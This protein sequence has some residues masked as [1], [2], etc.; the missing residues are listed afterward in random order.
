MGFSCCIFLVL[1]IIEFISS[2]SLVLYSISITLIGEERA[3]V[4]V[5]VYQL[6]CTLMLPLF[7][8]PIWFYAKGYMWFMMFTLHHHHCC[9][10]T[11]KDLTNIWCTNLIKYKNKVPKF[12]VWICP[13]NMQSNKQHLFACN[14][15]TC[16]TLARTATVKANWQSH[17]SHPKLWRNSNTSFQSNDIKIY[18]TLKEANSNDVIILKQNSTNKIAITEEEWT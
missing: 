13:W 6:A 15:N 12:Y 5:F 3:G 17:R 9:F 8:V 11:N 10:I 18:C 7:C 1:L 4:Y 16:Q 2:A 14:T